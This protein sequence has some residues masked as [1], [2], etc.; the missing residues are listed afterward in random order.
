MNEENT[1]R[2]RRKGNGDL[3]EKIR[4]K[5]HWRTKTDR[6]RY[7][8]EEFSRKRV[9]WEKRPCG[10]GE[11]VCLKAGTRFLVT[12]WDVFFIIH[13]PLVLN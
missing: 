11:Y 9:W 1:W 3:T 7:L 13:N 10:R 6:G 4:F 2:R 5:Q 12:E 8:G